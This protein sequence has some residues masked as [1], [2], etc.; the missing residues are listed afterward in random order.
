M[1]YLHKK[2]INGK[3]YYSLRKNIKINGKTIKKDVCSLG[4]DISKID[5]KDLEKKYPEEL[6]K[7]GQV[8][9]KTL[10]LNYYL[11]KVKKR[12]LKED[13][14]FD[15]GQLIQI[16]AIL[17]HFRRKFKKADNSVK[18]E[19]LENFYTNF[20]AENIAIEENINPKKEI[21][22]LL[23]NKQIKRN[24]SLL[25]I[26]KI[27][28]TKEIL[29]FLK[30][31]KPAINLSLI[32]KISN[33]FVKN[34]GWIEN[35][36]NKEIKL[37]GDCFK[38]SPI[39]EIKTDLKKLLNWF[40]KEKNKIHPLALATLFH[41]KFE[42]IHPLSFGNGEIGRILLNYILFSLNYP[43]LIIPRKLKQE[44]FDSMNKAY[45][46]LKK[47]LLNTDIKY[48]RPLLDFMHKQFVKTYW[49]YFLA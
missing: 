27:I 20:I 30:N 22:N 43:L 19:I 18:K 36:R 26:Y 23:K 34:I 47:D 48:Y 39:K 12:K 41:H 28:N 11:E 7:S 24:K 44:Y 3:N 37:I 35:Y 16:N 9:K 13:D 8:I 4:S 31:K 29:D 6:K 32:K 42:K 46:C 33:L 2:N 10:D 49:N 40:N 45:P 38:P 1:A 21:K 17:M 14:F 5:L 25:D 15:K